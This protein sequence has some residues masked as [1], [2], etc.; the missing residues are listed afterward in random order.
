VEDGGEHSATA[1]VEQMV[2][3]SAKSSS[4]SQLE[5]IDGAVRRRVTK[6]VL[7]SS[8]APF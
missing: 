3:S 5:T 2:V 7:R 6:Q 4:S 8:V 1:V